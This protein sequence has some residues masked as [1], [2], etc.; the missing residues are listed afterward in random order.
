MAGRFKVEG[1]KFYERLGTG[2][3]ATVF[4]AKVRYMKH[5]SYVQTT[6][7]LLTYISAESHIIECRPETR[8]ID[9]LIIEMVFRTGT[10]FSLV[11]YN[12]RSRQMRGELG[13]FTFIVHQCLYDQQF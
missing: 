6:I 4:K 3:Y 9:N 7:L 13:C 8:L 10:T 2:T 11:H 5:A 12:R 1:Y